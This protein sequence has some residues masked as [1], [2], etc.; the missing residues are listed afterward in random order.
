MKKP[1]VDYET[2]IGC[3]SGV[4]ICPVVFELRSYEKTNEDIDTRIFDIGAQGTAWRSCS[5]Y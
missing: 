3:G 2:C 5:N 4:E 1:I